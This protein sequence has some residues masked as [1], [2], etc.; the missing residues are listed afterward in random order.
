LNAIQILVEEHR[1][2]L[3]GLDLLTTA[4]EKIVRNQNPPRAF[5]E[6]A[7]SLTLNFTNKF[8]HYKEEIV[9]FGLLAQKHEG[10]FDSEIERLRDQH[11]SLHNYMNEISKSLDAYSKS[12][13]S[14]VRRLHR[15]L[16]DYIETLRRHIN[17]EN[18]IFYP[19]V[20]KTLTENEMQW[21][22]KEFEKY[23][24]KEGLGA[25]KEYESLIGEMAEL[26]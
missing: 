22:G 20:A 11:H 12:I 10:A 13:Q 2:I 25:M 24:A 9:M 15:N 16:S 23:A 14:E 1:V 18:A 6:K 8:H 19:L 4:A 5:F 7:V 21:L 17:A 26:V 3:R